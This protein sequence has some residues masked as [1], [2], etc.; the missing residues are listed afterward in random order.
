MHTLY[1]L[2]RKI[3]TNL[4]INLKFNLEMKKLIL[5]FAAAFSLCAMNKVSSQVI[6]SGATGDCTWTLTEISGDTV[7]IISGSG[8]MDDYDRY[9]QVYSPWYSY[10]NSIKTADVQQ[11]VT[12][13]GNFAFF[14]C[15]GLTSVT[16][17]NSVTTIGEG[18]FSDCTGLTSVTIGNSV[19]TI[20]IYAFYNCDNLTSV[21]IPNSV[22]TIEYGAFMSC[23]NLASVSIGSSV[24]TIKD[25]AFSNCT[26]LTS[27]TIPNSVTTL[28]EGAFNHCTGLTSATIGNSVTAVEDRVFFACTNLI[29][30]T[31]PNS[32]T[33]IGIE[34]FFGCVGLTS[35]IIPNSVTLLKVSAFASCTGLTSAVIP[36]SVTAV[37]EGAFYGCTG[38]TSVTIGNSVTTVS[39]MAFYNCIGLTEIYVKAETPPQI[40]S[41]TFEN[42][43]VNIPVYVCGEVE[44]Y[45]NA[46][47][48]NNF[49]NIL[50]DNTCN[51]AV[52]DLPAEDIIN[53]YPN[54]AT[55][56]IVIS[57]R[58]MITNA[59][60]TLYDMQGKVLIRRNVSNEDVIS[61]NEF[62]AGVYIYNVSTGKENLN[63]KIVISE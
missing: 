40:D 14:G 22:T 30:V 55:D 18:A 27:I 23:P 20:G 28:A 4:F 17:G 50:P 47:C 25:Y 35:V 21:T 9:A 52:E 61:V 39:D 48:W 36:N 11:G 60:F 12:N 57:L 32:V 41:N 58:E 24:T 15:S 1:F 49:T 5:L 16:I 6:S 37:R 19:D 62:A 29:S 3:L 7:L 13:I 63:G 51:V 31:I 56:N 45:R 44:D 46:S 42:V 38:L 10:G 33:S 34:A 59:V 43:S 53:I 8:V 54:P 26:G 2:Q